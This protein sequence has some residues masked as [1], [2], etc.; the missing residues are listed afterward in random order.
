MSNYYVVTK[1]GKSGSVAFWNGRELLSADNSHPNFNRIVA[2]LENGDDATALFNPESA[3]RRE[4]RHLS[5]RV[6]VSNGNV[7][8]D[9][10]PVVDK[11]T[12]KIVDA[13]EK[14]KSFA[15]FVRFLEKCYT[16]PNEHSRIN[17]F[18][19]LEANG[20]EINGSGDI[21]AYKG[22]NSDFS[23]KHVG[24]GIVNGVEVNR[25]VSAPGNIVEMARS[26]V[27][28]DP[29][30]GCSHGLHIANWDYARSWGDVVVQVLV[31]PRD[32]VSVPTDSGEQKMRVCRYIAIDEVT[33]PIDAFS[34]YD[35]IRD[36]T[37]AQVDTRQNYKKLQRD[38]KGRF[39][40][41]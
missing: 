35:N 38:S 21:I 41:A 9:G 24:P 12:E 23:S 28:H 8:F 27:Q 16:N 13:L 17:L 39:V 5:E 7:Y 26:E 19:W 25:V 11:I 37:I 4:F 29:S 36:D 22:T 10:D 40:K 6:A 20:F 31:N 30:Q 3:I 18:R 2:A 34:E 32:V 1:Q 14:N 33:H 15:P